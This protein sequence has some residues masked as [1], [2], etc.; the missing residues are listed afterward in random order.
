MSSSFSEDLKSKVMNSGSQLN[1]I[2]QKIKES[3]DRHSEKQNDYFKKYFINCENSINITSLIFKYILF[4][5][6]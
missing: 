6:F 4:K 5:M 2:L 3:F 1:T